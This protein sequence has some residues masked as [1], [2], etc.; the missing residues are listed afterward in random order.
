VSREVSGDPGVETTSLKAA[1]LG[2]GIALESVD[3]LGGALGASR[4]GRIQ[5]LT[6]LSPAM[7]FT[8]LVH[9][10]AHLCSVV[11][12]VESGRR[13]QAGKT[14]PARATIVVDLRALVWL[15]VLTESWAR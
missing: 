9:E 1:I 2:Q 4:G 12:Y 6:C 7:A 3:D 14:A 8:T 15:L 5:L 10:Y 13:G 11:G